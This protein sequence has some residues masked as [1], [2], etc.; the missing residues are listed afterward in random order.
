M[1]YNVDS[2]DEFFR[3]SERALDID[4]TDGHRLVHQYDSYRAYSWIIRVPDITSLIENAENVFNFSDANDILTL[5]ARKVS[6]L[7]YNVGVIQADKVNDK[8]HYP[9]RPNTT[10]VLITFDNLIKGDVQ[11][12]L[13]T[14]MRTSYDP[15]F[16]VHSS[17]VVTG[18]QFKRTLEIIQLDHQKNPAL[19]IKLY[20]AFPTKFQINDLDYG[21]EAFN[22]IEMEVKYDFMTTYKVEDNSFENF[23]GS[24][25]PGV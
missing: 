2:V 14:W 11:K 22:T 5:A 9:G 20:G 6:G 1:V 4:I 10:P 21:N 12:V 13:N 24:L 3:Q 15:I 23:L 17:P 16:G 7:A 8:F 25:I 18:G 19:V